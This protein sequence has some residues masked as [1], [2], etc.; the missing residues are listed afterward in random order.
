M[1]KFLETKC[2]AKVNLTLDVLNKRP[3]GYHNLE[4]IMHEAGPY[5]IIAVEINTEGEGIDLSCTRSDIPLGSDNTCYRA[6]EQFLNAAGI[7]AQINIKITKN[8]P[9]G[10]GL[11]GGSSDA[12]GVIKALDALFGC[13]MEKDKM[14]EIGKAVGADVPFFIYGGC[15][16]AEG[17]GE[18]LTPLKELSGA[19]ILIA[20][21][22]LSVSTPYVF[23]KFRLSGKLS[24]P[25]T[26][27]CVEAVKNGD[28]AAL[29]AAAGNVLESVTEAENPVIGEYKKIMKSFGAAY[30]LMSGSGPSVFGV[31]EC[32]QAAERARA[33]F[34]KITN[35]VYI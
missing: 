21:P 30:S 33:E 34:L 16:L 6:A 32:E 10:A 1:R 20:K 24:H 19:R 11:G 29:S 7:R 35:E 31:F 3:D 28:L 18:R 14:A 17:I 8:I 5:D 15:A 26:A 27:A 4:M 9:A 12:A 25:N 13:R 2:R 22:N 23:K